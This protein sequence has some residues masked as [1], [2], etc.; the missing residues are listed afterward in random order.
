MAKEEFTPK[1]LPASEP[2]VSDI[3]A[4][5]SYMLENGMC[6]F[7]VLSDDGYNAQV[8]F[9]NPNY[10]GKFKDKES[11]E[12]DDPENEGKKKTITRD[13]D[14]D[15]FPNVTKSIVIPKNDDGTVDVAAFKQ[16]LMDQARGVRTRMDAGLAL[17]QQA[18][19]SDSVKPNSL[20]GFSNTNKV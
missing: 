11:Y 10:T 7:K 5:K 4:T 13:I 6:E 12:I 9:K 16:R 3:N 1:E 8:E 17:A 19:K 20:A 14:N 18:T 15:P 2:S